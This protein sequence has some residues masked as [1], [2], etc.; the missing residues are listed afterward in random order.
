VSSDPVR[1]ETFLAAKLDPPGSPPDR[2]PRERLVE[3]VCGSPG[4]RVAL[5][6][7]PAGFGKSTL[8]LQCRERLA[9]EGVATAWLSLDRADN[10]ASRFLAG[11]EAAVA[12]LEGGGGAQTLVPGK[13]RT[14][15]EIALAVFER[16]ATQP[17][18]FALFLDELEAIHEPG[19]IDL[20]REFIGHL[21]Q[22]G[23]L[24]IGS[25]SLPDLHLGRLRARGQLLEVDASRLRFTID[26]TRAFLTGSRGL[27]LAFDELALLH[28]KTEGWAAGLWLASVALQ[29]SE[30]PSSFIERF[31]GT[32]QSVADY[33]AEDVLA[34]QKP[35]V[36]DF[37][38]RT[39]IL[40]VLEAPLC[41]ALLPGQ[42]AE[43]ILAELETAN[44][45]LVPVGSEPRRYRY[46]A[47]FARFLQAQL[48]REAPGELPRLHAAAAR[49]Y[50]SVER[51]VPAID[52]AIES[53]NA[54]HAIVLLER[55]ARELLAQGRLRLLSRW[56]DALPRETLLAHPALQ[57]A[58]IWALSFTRGAWDGMRLLEASGLESSEDESV[59][60]HVR[61]LRP[62]LL[63]MM[64]RYEEASELGR[65][66]LA[67]LPTRDAFANDVLANVMA[68]VVSVIGTRREARELIDSARR[69]QGVAA[70]AFNRM[71]SETS[72]GILDLQEGRLRQATARFRMAVTANAR[73]GYAYTNGNAWA[74]VPYALARYEANDLDQAAHLLQ[75]YLPLARDVGLADLVI[76]GYMTMA[77]I[78]FVR[79]DID[80]V[81]QM[82]IEMEYLGNRR[83]LPRVVASAKLERARVLLLQGHREAAHDELDRAEA[84]A[85]WPRIQALRFLANDLDYLALAR[86]RWDAHAGNAAKAAEALASA[87]AEAEQAARHRR[88]LKLRLLL[89]L[90]LYRGGDR[91][92]SFKA[93]DLVLERACSEGFVRLLLDE[94]EVAGALVQAREVESRGPRPSSSDPILADFL[95]QLARDFG[96][97]P[98]VAEAP[99]SQDVVPL[100]DPLT[101]KEI[102]VLQLLAEGYSNSAMAEK[103]FVSDS[104][105]RTHLR[106]INAKLDATS[107]TQAVAIAR[108]L[109]VIR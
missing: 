55:H 39:S 42:D 80:R 100:P 16:L 69:G 89:A 73:G 18:P 104:T 86:L 31:S 107:R 9:D 56:F 105:V 93:L 30:T 63:A 8:L 99:G 78:E 71:Y 94:G 76:V 58:E 88:A 108:R 40:R 13:P 79:G 15:S 102:R 51:P 10:D 38:L 49:W 52:H 43:T 47:L 22:G 65:Q 81:L 21:P 11:L 96:P 50:E 57:L 44:V 67:H 1:L 72:D 74:G 95:Q 17:T 29:R 90:A 35:K 91:E 5:L 7:A 82:L 83:Q 61:A 26:E 37:L 54:A 12:A 64:D 60:A 77:R 14:A 106:N 84:A 62:L 33:L 46:H 20:L 41:N 59:L 97:L 6:R 32:D 24:V 75:V 23:R 19:I 2:I 36:R 87:L 109:G 48:V 98:S 3:L 45:L 101:R 28:G 103:L 66:S 34:R 68:T 70:S 25:R 27:R 92:A 4:Y 85:S 53:G